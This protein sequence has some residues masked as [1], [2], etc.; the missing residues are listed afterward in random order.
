ME[1]RCRVNLAFVLIKYHIVCCDRVWRGR[2]ASDNESRNIV[3]RVRAEPEP[4]FFQ[5]E[6]RNTIKGQE[7]GY[8]R[9]NS[10]PGAG[11]SVIRGARGG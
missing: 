5:T 3:L 4:R 2:L 1:M 8:T 9:I 11:K 7:P 6:Y 10:L